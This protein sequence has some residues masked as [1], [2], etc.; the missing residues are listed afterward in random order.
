[1]VSDSAALA[2]APNPAGAVEE[3][4][5]TLHAPVM[6]RELR[7]WDCLGLPNHPGELARGDPAR[8]TYI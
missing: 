4:A 3:D 8:L 6:L 1:M 5:P 2:I 7:V